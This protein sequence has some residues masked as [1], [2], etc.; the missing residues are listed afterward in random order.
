M[1]QFIGSL[2]P[3]EDPVSDLDLLFT[4]VYNVL[5]EKHLAEPNKGIV[6]SKGTPNQ[7]KATWSEILN[8][9]HS[10]ED[11]FIFRQQR[12]GSGICQTCRHWESISKQSPHMGRCKLKDVQPVHAW[13]SCKK[14]KEKAVK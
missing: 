12:T 8:I 7:R 3:P 1:K 9:A 5:Y 2:K 14:H 6:V 13:A 11:Y 10:V 4:A